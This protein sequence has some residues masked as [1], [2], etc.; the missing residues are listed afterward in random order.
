MSK[1]YD[2]AAVGVGHNGLVGA[3]Y[4]AEFGLKTPV[5]DRLN[6]VDGAAP[7]YENAPG[8]GARICSD[9]TGHLHPRIVA[10]PDRRPGPKIMP[11]SGVLVPFDGGACADARKSVARFNK[12][13]AKIHPCAEWPNYCFVGKDSLRCRKRFAA[14]AAR[15][16]AAIGTRPFLSCA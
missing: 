16:C 13:D 9:L 4:P 14:K 8:F 11:R 5:L 10:D 2:V 12:R 3:A 15:R 1:A 6:V 7:T